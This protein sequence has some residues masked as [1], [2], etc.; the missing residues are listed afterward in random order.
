[1]KNKEGIFVVKS[2]NSDELLLYMDDNLQPVLIELDE[3][4][5]KDERFDDAIVFINK[6]IKPDDVKKIILVNP[7]LNIILYFKKDLKYSEIVE[8]VKSGIVDTVFVNDSK[9]IRLLIDKYSKGSY[10]SN[11]NYYNNLFMKFAEIGIIT[12]NIKMAEIFSMVEKIS[13]SNSTVLIYG[14][15][16]TG[17]ELIAK[18][19]HYFSK[20]RDYNFVAVNTGAIPENLL[21]DE[22]FGH[23]KG[24]FT[25]AV[26]DRKGK[27][28]YAHRGT[29]FLDEISNMPQALQVKLLRIL[30]EREFERI[31]D[32]QTISVDVRVISATN[33]D[34]KELVKKGDFREDLYY[35]LNV[36][37]IYMLPLRERKSDIPL[38]ANYFVRKYCLLN[39]ISVKSFNMASLRIL[40]EYNWPGNV[41][42]LENII[43]RMVVLN[44]EVSMFMPSHIPKEIKTNMKEEKPAKILDEI[45]E[46]GISLNTI[47]KNIERDLILKSLE[48]T[49]W[50]KQKAANL[51]GIKRTT[52]IEKLKKLNKEDIK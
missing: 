21:E 20:R 27:F 44:P 48:K 36:I 17:K 33:K 2:T 8:Y 40:K 25:S 34:L 30:Q 23:V 47:I 14:E 7:G 3:L 35:R 12:N 52:L 1:M 19:I 37:P 15:S 50:N 38:L 41:R 22:L 28:E 32:N 13:A 9:L 39:N 6:E 24:S 5:F 26:K 4:Y 43:E 49:S 45:P 42:Q 11:I 18:S 16:G 51:L 46:E 31:G 29:V 10:S